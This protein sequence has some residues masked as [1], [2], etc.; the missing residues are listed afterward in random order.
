MEPESS[1]PHSEQPATLPY[2][3]PHPSSPWPPPPITLLECPF[4][5]PHLRLGLPSGFFPSDLATKILYVHLLSPIRATCPVQLIC[6]Y[7][8]TRIKFREQ[9]RSLS[10][11]FCSFLHSPV[12]LSLLG[13][14]IFSTLFSDTLSLCSSLKVSDQVSHPYKTTDNIILLCILIFIFFIS[15]SMVSNSDRD[16]DS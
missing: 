4:L 6:H 7:L 12:T 16:I 2:P 14:N 1:S 15:N 9:Y 11:S 8:I 13:S 10:S 3:E 5:Y